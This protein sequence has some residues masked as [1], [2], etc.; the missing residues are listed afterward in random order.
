MAG[1]QTGPSAG[2][3]DSLLQKTTLEKQKRIEFQRFRRICLLMRDKAH[4]VKQGFEQ[5]LILARDLPVKY[6]LDASLSIDL[7]NQ[8]DSNSRYV[9]S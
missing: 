7:H 9:P 1:I 6:D 2:T 8:T 5:C 3:H 4:L